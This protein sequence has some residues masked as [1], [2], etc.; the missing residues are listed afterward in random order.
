MVVPAQVAAH[1]NP[2]CSP[3]NPGRLGAISGRRAP[4]I[5][6]DTGN[7]LDPDRS[8][9]GPERRLAAP[10]PLDSPEMCRPLREG[11]A[12]Y[13][14]EPQRPLVP[15][16]TGTQH[17]CFCPPLR[18]NAGWREGG[19]AGGRVGGRA[20]WRGR[21]RGRRRGRPRQVGRPLSLIA[22]QKYLRQGRAPPRDRPVRDPG[23]PSRGTAGEHCRIPRIPLRCNAIGQF[24]SVRD[25]IE[26]NSPRLL[27]NSDRATLFTFDTRP[28]AENPG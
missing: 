26:K 5:G 4:G 22:G 8:H 25:Q 2:R 10:H 27:L 12:R 11:S 24:I 28:H 6:R 7:H 19:L 9:G 15:S 1:L 18:D 23:H 20:G 14:G 21:S 13:L 17:H 3:A 16:N